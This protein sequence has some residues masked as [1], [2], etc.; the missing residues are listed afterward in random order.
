MS[1]TPEELAMFAGTGVGAIK[2]CPAAGDLVRRIW[3]E[4]V[5][6]AT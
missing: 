4:C 1:G 5:G 3:A 6:T 2:D